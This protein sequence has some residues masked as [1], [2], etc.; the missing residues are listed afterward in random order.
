M[1][2]TASAEAETSLEEEEEATASPS[3]IPLSS[4]Q[5]EST[6]STGEDL[7]DRV[8]RRAAERRRYVSMC[9]F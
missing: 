9:C 1:A 2:A 5:L 4:N 7:A 3:S 8:R 6:S